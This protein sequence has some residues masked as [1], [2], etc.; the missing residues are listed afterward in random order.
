MYFLRFFLQLQRSPRSYVCVLE[1]REGDGRGALN[2]HITHINLSCF[3]SFTF[4]TIIYCHYYY[5]YCLLS[6]SLHTFTH[7]SLQP[8][9]VR[10]QTNYS[11]AILCDSQ[12]VHIWLG[13][14]LDLTNR[15]YYWASKVSQNLSL[16]L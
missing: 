5:Y 12:N 8:L 15:T 10:L 1:V 4:T 7:I 2:T 6:L 14:L 13:T 3:V 16:F 9:S 11:G